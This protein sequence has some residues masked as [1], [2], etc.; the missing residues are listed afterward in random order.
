MDDRAPV[1]GAVRLVLGMGVPGVDVFDSHSEAIMMWFARGIPL[2]HGEKRD[3]MLTSREVTEAIGAFIATR[4]EFI[5]DFN[6][7]VKYIFVEGRLE[8][9]EVVIS[10]R[11][12]DPPR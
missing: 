9:A 2:R 3:F 8:R 7:N 1:P 10:K 11:D 5:G 12:P 4:E 6:C